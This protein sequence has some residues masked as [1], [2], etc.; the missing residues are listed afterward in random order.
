MGASDTALR[1]TGSYPAPQV[2]IGNLASALVDKRVSACGV[3][4]LRR[5]TGLGFLL[6]SHAMGAKS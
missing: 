3:L 4:A 1:L 5:F 6:Y 2:R